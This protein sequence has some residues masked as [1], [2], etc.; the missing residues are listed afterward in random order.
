MAE[1]LEI[2]GSARTITGKA[3]RRLAGSHQLAAVLY[4]VGHDP[5][6]IAVDRHDFEMLAKKESLTSSLVSL[7]VDDG[8]AV[9]VIIKAIQH[10]P[11]KGTI[12]H[13]DFWAVSMTQ[14]IA[15]QVPIHFTGD[16]P[17]ERNGGVMMHNLQQVHIEA[18]ATALPEHLEVD[19]S[20]LE[21]G[22][23]LHVRDLI[24]PKGVTV[25][26]PED[27]IVCAVHVQRTAEA[28][29]GAEEI[30]EPEVVGQSASE[31]K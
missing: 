5:Q 25:M 8:K 23:S 3:N 6:P 2:K 27:E 28:E 1:M 9:N 15:T 19:V 7:V 31:E 20:S 30:T 24:V 10:D 17:G 18:L 29:E 21:I 22:D 4:G 16:A 14:K 11:V 12:M 26:D 13:A